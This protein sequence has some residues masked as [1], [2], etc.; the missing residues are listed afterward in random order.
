MM[1]PRSHLRL[2]LAARELVLQGSHPKLE[3]SFKIGSLVLVNAAPWYESY[4]KVP[5]E[6]KTF[7]RDR[8]LVSNF[9]VFSSYISKIIVVD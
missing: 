3:A 7:F 8:L 1:L 9:K 6:T 2:W 4:P 5:T